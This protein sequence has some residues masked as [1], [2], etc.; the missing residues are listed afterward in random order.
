MN[1]QGA[2]LIKKLEMRSRECQI[3]SKTASRQ[4]AFTS[5]KA[6]SVLPWQGTLVSS[7]LCKLISMDEIHIFSSLFV[8]LL[9]LETQLLPIL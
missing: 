4:T 9:K 2:K 7:G 8:T 3:T 6:L 5:N 1:F